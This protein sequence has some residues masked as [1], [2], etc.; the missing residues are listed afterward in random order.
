[1]SKKGKLII[2]LISLL[3]LALIPGEG[4]LTALPPVTETD[5]SM[6]SCYSAYDT[7]YAGLAYNAGSR[8]DRFDFRWSDIESSAGYFN[9]GPHDQMVN[10]DYEQ[11]I[12]I[13][14]ILG[15][16][17]AWA[18]DPTCPN[19]TAQPAT[20]SPTSA[21]IQWEGATGW[22]YH[23]PPATRYEPWTGPDSANDW[24]NYVYQVVN[25]LRTA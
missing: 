7:T 14:G 23:C 8:W 16:T 1:M 4:R 19:T 6:G 22:P 13:L 3:N 21:H 24:G 11:G 15:S 17:P 2:T 12:Q 9:F 25:H 5:S 20:R 18:A 10:R